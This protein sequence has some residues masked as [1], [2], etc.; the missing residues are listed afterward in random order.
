MPVQ[1]MTMLSGT[2]TLLG[3][4]LYV[5]GRERIGDSRWRTG[6]LISSV[7]LGLGT[8]LGVLSK[9]NAALLPLLARRR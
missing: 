4:I 2:F 8:I 5:I 1:R 3:L 9:E 6:L 7:R